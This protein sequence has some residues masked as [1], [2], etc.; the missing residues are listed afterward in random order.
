MSPRL[1]DPLLMERFDEICRRIAA[2][3]AGLTLAQLG[4]A[5]A[6]AR[7][8]ADP[9]P[10]AGTIRFLRGRLGLGEGDR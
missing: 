3:G 9:N 5:H 8:E 2:Q 6:L 10:D 1:G 7:E 4:D